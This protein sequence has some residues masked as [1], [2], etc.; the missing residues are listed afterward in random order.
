MKSFPE[1]VLLATDGLERT[2]LAS[3][4]VLVVGGHPEHKPGSGR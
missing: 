2:I 4:T 3:R 1:K